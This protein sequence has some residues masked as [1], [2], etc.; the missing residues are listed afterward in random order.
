MEASRQS[1]IQSVGYPETSIFT[2]HNPSQRDDENARV[3]C[4]AE[5]GWR[6]GARNDAK[7]A[8]HLRQVENVGFAAPEVARPLRGYA[9]SVPSNVTSVVR[10]ATVF[11]PCCRHRSLF[12]DTGVA[13]Q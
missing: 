13:L 1:L 2:H 4:Q 8:W 5:F 10:E 11:L 6:R 7:I 9:P 12:L 3:A